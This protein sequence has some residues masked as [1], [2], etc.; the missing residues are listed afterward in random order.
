ME[1]PKIQTADSTM[2]P[3]ENKLLLQ[4]KGITKWYPVGGGRTYVLNNVDL[5][6]NEGDF[7]SIMGPSGSGKSTLLHIIGMLDEPNEGEYYFLG[8][9][10]LD[11]KE[12]QRSQLYKQ[13][14][15]FVF[16]QY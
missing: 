6:V 9:S 3:P 10:V 1:N 13:H 5:D 14:I 16:Q 8:E 15:G 2:P 4:L 11:L 7:I 12:K